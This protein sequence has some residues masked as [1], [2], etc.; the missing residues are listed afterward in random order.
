MP[1]MITSPG[2]GK[3]SGTKKPAPADPETA[4]NSATSGL[5]PATPTP[6]TSTP[7]LNN[8]TPPGF[9]A[10]GSLSFRSALPVSTPRPGCDPSMDRAGGNAWPGKNV[11]LNPQPRLV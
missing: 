1:S 10:V 8:G 2:K 3:G 7:C 9:T 6:P 11:V 4:A 5:T